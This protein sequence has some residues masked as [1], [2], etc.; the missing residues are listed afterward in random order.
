MPRSGSAPP[1]P[2]SVFPASVGTEPQALPACTTA[3]SRPWPGRGTSGRRGRSSSSDGVCASCGSSYPLVANG[4]SR[5][6]R[7]SGRRHSCTRRF[8]SG[9][10]V[11]RG[12]PP[13]SWCAAVLRGLAG[14]SWGVPVLLPVPRR[15]RA[16]LLSRDC[17]RQDSRGALNSARPLHSIH[18][19]S[20]TLP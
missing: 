2:L 15:G 10:A 14:Q 7:G 5:A 20:G 3:E 17:S 8:G 4:V 6:R 11:L 18:R 16:Q 9:A 1:K 12:L 13:E 19:E